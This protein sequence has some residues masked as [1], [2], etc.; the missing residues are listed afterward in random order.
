M[1]LPFRP[2]DV[3][4]KQIVGS[5]SLPLQYRMH[6]EL[7]FK[8][9]AQEILRSLRGSKSQAYLNK[10]LGFTG[11]QVYRWEKG[12]RHIDWSDFV[13]VCRVQN[14]DLL[15]IFQ[16]HFGYKEKS[17]KG[18]LLVEYFVG[19]LTM[20]D[21]V[22]VT[23]F[24]RSVLTKWMKETTSPQLHH[25]LQL[26]EFPNQ[27]LLTFV[28]EVAGTYHFQS[29]EKYENHIQKLKEF[30]YA[31]PMLAGITAFLESSCFENKKEFVRAM[32]QTFHTDEGHIESLL[33]R[34]AQLGLIEDTKSVAK[35][36]IRNVDTR[37]SFDGSLRL[38]KYWY[39][40]ALQ[41]LEKLQPQQTH[42]LFP[43]V[44]FC[45]SEKAEKKLR[46][47][48]YHYLAQIKAIVGE[49][50]G[51]KNI[52]RAIAISDVALTEVAEAKKP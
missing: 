8:E 20:K 44:V 30:Y 34:M 41:T 43:F 10:K 26:I 4:K 9:L 52:V 38:R 15:K 24:S 27:L 37:G 47:A 11:N 42:H 2:M 21:A 16:V 3:L 32:A 49:D 12:L 29:L 48:H 19:N 33:K 7:N 46:E 35:V 50:A 18:A 40:F 25:I 36:K 14:V 22:Q 6:A 51:D 17:L 45:I 13:E 1:P 39:R 28:R 5:G 23:G 31:E